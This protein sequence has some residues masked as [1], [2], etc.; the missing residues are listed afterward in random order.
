MTNVQILHGDLSPDLCDLARASELVG[1]DIETSGL[2]WR[3]GQIGTCQLAIGDSVAVVVLGDDDHPQGLCD[4]LADDGVRKI[5]HH[6]PFD[7]RFMAQ[8]WDCKPRNLAC[9][10]IA[11]KVLNP[12]AEHATHSL[13]PLLKA[14]LGVD[15]DKGQQQSSWTTGVLTAEQMSYAVSD[16]V[17]LSELYSQLRAQCLDKGVLQAVENAYSFLPVWVEL[18]RRGIEDVFAY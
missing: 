4:L 12:S 7:I 9:T 6:A 13:K 14:T 2:D 16:V 11:S 1:W 10:K 3:N 5:F 17:Y 15:I 8:Q 18:Q